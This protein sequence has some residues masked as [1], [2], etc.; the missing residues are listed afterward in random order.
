MSRSEPSR[1]R[2][3]K[4]KLLMKDTSENDKSR[5]IGL[6]D[7]LITSKQLPSSG[8]SDANISPYTL[9]LFVRYTQLQI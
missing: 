3:C 7:I 9:A 2:D 6:R 1:I 8:V 5:Q 4:A